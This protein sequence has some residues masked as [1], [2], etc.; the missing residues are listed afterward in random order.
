MW[1]AETRQLKSGAYE[2]EIEGEQILLFPEKFAFWEKEKTVF[3]ADTHF[4]KVAHFRK[5]GIGLPAGAGMETFFRLQE[6]ILNLKPQRVVILGDVFHSDFNRD[7][8]R[9]KDWIS[10]FPNTQFDLVL[11]NH[12]LA[13]KRETERLG[14]S[15]K[16]ELEL[17]P[18]LCL[19]EPEP[20]RNHPFQFF[21]HL[22]PGIAISGLAGQGVKVPGFWLGESHLCFPAF[23]A[24]TGCV[25]IQPKKNEIMFALTANKVIL[26][27]P[28]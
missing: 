9:F 18:F 3:L 17:G 21:G 4:G 24:F 20:D 13:G 1:E 27:Q 19:H 8:V 5:S 7:F 12:D 2:L 15:F 6:I 10:Q 23:G 11:G 16:K 14:L 26:I 22:H 28:L 25:A